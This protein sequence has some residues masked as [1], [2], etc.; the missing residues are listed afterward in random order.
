MK[1]KMSFKTFFSCVSLVVRER[2]GLA[3]LEG[4][5]CFGSAICTGLMPLVW[6]YV[7]EAIENYIALSDTKKILYAVILFLTIQAAEGVF[8]IIGRIPT[9]VFCYNE[10]LQKKLCA[11]LY[12]HAAN[13]PYE[14]FLDEEVYSSFSKANASVN[15]N[16][17][18]NLLN[19]FF[20]T[21][22]LLLSLWIAIITLGSFSPW[23][24]LMAL[25]SL[26]PLSMIQKKTVDKFYDVN[27]KLA[28]ISE[29]SNYF[30]SLFTQPASAAEFRTYGCEKEFENAWQ[31]NIKTENKIKKQ[32][33]KRTSWQNILGELFKLCGF[34][35]ALIFSS[36]LL[37]MGKIS[38][39]VLGAVL[40]A[41]N[42]MQQ[43]SNQLVSNLLQINQ[44]Y[45][46]YY[47]FDR[48]IKKKSMETLEIGKQNIRTVSMM[49]VSY[50][51]PHSN[52][53]A[54]D[55]VDWCFSTDERIAIVGENGSGKSTLCMLLL[56]LLVPSKGEVNIRLSDN[57]E[58]KNR[59]ISRRI[60]AV[61]Q[62]FVKY[63]LT[64]RENLALGNLKLVGDDQAL[65]EA[66]RNISFRKAEKIDL[67]AQIGMEFGGI[68]FS[69]GEWQKIAL[70]RGTLA[71]SDFVIMDEPTASLDPMVE[72]DLLHS[73]L[74]SLHKR[75]FILVTHRIG[76]ARLAD[77]IIVM[78]HGKIVQSGNHDDLIATDGEYSRLF[79]EQAKWY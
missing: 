15:R 47:D 36:V 65:L 48:F 23:L 72:Y 61:F 22:S 34:V 51:Y 59:L 37:S 73:M 69:L 16:L 46:F 21:P 35:V 45:L 68:D 24:I 32:Y 71:N 10:Q 41:Y 39:G 9:R 62:D 19:T 56:G 29:K 76:A 50:R 52:T 28:P 78:K 30:Y 3:F 67:D 7:F 60:S 54:I 20:Q 17:P 44:S 26:I 58:V 70:V 55:S 11:K 5:S 25:I 64:L 2:P 18:M 4:L 63:H 42:S 27:Q 14:D 31:E 40:T 57:R 66:L 79:Y 12:S 6:A 74:S 33:L 77:K 49:N 43:T 53:L 1:K 75:G 13:L 8:R 38:I